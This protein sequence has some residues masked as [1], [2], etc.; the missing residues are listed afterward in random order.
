M[1]KL[2][3]S[4]NLDG[5][6]IRSMLRYIFKNT[7][8][9]ILICTNDELRRKKNENVSS[10]DYYAYRLMIRRDQ[11]NVSLRCHELCQQFLVVLYV[12][13]ESKRF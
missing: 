12:K 4:D 1:N 13:I 11:D 5:D 9:E 7:N 3:Q 8:I 10:K 2:G 6:K